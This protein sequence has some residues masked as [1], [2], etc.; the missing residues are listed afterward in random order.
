VWVGLGIF[1]LS[2]GTLAGVDLLGWSVTTKVWTDFAKVLAPV[3]DAYAKLPGVVSLLA[4]YL[5]M[6]AVA[7]AGAVAL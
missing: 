4:T 3:S 7:T 5:F 2:L 6:L 1:A